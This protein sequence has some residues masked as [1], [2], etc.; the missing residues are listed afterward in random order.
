MGKIKISSFIYYIIRLLL[1][2][3]AETRNDDLLL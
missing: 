1:N 3:L 2:T